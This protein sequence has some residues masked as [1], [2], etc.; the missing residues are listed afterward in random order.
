MC[1]R[2]P[3]THEP[4]NRPIHPSLLQAQENLRKQFKVYCLNLVVESTDNK[5]TRKNKK[6]KENLNKTEQNK[7]YSMLCDEQTSPSFQKISLHWT[8]SILNIL[9]S[10][11]SS[12]TIPFSLSLSVS[13]V[14]SSPP[15]N[16]ETGNSCNRMVWLYCMHAIYYS[17]QCYW[18]G[19][20]QEKIGLI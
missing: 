18:K 11:S 15:V 4:L 3:L 12:I 16:R 8:T 5:N 20:S 6:N 10:F 9:V 1:D 7:K 17:I 2:P 14:E 13:S 19:L